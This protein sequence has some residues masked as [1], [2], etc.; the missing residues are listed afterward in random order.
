MLRPMRLGVSLLA[1]LMASAAVGLLLWLGKPFPEDVPGYGAGLLVAAF[2]GASLVA[3]RTA[4]SVVRWPPLSASRAV[5]LAVLAYACAM[6]LWPVAMAVT[7]LPSVWAGGQVPCIRIGGNDAWLCGH[8]YS[9]MREIGALIDAAM[10]WYRIGPLVFIFLLPYGLLF[11]A[12]LS[13]AWAR[14]L[15]WVVAGATGPQQDSGAAPRPGIGQVLRAGLVLAA[16]MELP[17]V[18]LLAWTAS[19]F[20]EVIVRYGAELMGAVA[21]AA[22]IVATMAARETPNEGGDPA[23]GRSGPVKI[24]LM[25]FV[26]VMVLWPAVISLLSLPGVLSGGPTPCLQGYCPQ[27]GAGLADLASLARTTLMNYAGLGYMLMATLPVALA[28]GVPLCWAWLRTVADPILDPH[29]S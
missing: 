22:L 28:I 6:L 20:P 19:S 26:W 3:G 21:L 14:V 15:R 24:G 23:V 10:S 27:G 11:G 29:R 25:V 9:G 17:A 13:W 16:L 12:P 2:L 5:W 7:S 1:G 18:L 4:P 8:G